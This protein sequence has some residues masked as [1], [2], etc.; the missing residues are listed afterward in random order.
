MKT[1]PFPQWPNPLDK[2]GKPPPLKDK[3]N[4]KDPDN[5]PAPFS[6]A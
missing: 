1:W 3:F 5:E 6:N 4:P 2:G